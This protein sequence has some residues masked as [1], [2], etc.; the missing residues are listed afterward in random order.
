M[1]KEQCVQCHKEIQGQTKDDYYN[2]CVRPEC[3]NYG[4]VQVGNKSL[5]EFNKIK[6]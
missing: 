2:V 1:Q 6:K 4:L 5:K 3:P